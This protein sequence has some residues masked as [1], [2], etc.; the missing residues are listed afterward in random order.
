MPQAGL[1]NLLRT[2]RSTRR[3]RAVS[4][5]TAELIALA[6]LGCVVLGLWWFAP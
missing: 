5:S 1:S 2:V 3:R 4:I 6:L